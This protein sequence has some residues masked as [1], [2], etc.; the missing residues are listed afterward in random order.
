MKIN[1][2]WMALALGLMMLFA[3]CA[4]GAP[5]DGQLPEDTD[6]PGKELS[7]EKAFD[8]A[9]NLIYEP[10]FDDA[11]EMNAYTQYS[12]EDGELLDAV[13][14]DL[15]SN[16]IKSIQYDDGKAYWWTEYIYEDGVLV[17]DV[18]IDGSY[19]IYHYD[20]AG[21]DV[22]YSEYNGEGLIRNKTDR[23]NDR[24]TK[25][26]EYD[27]SGEVS[28]WTEYLY[29]GEKR[30][31]D[32]SSDGNYSIYHHNDSGEETGYTVYDADGN[33]VDEIVY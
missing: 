14:Y 9:G 17:K 7:K 16:P 30:V 24:I 2:K 31:K 8:D 1:K 5:G 3:L 11:G 15:A 4:C 27:E 25:Y 10:V 6:T 33:V 18:S 32:I 28:Y 20:D 12:Y 23:K 13:T 21:N 19:C 29:E 22:G 26:W